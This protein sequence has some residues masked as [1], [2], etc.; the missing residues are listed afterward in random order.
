M[1]AEIVMENEIIRGPLT[2]RITFLG[3]TAVGKTSI[4]NRII[5]NN[6]TAQYDPTMKV[7]CYGLNLNIS[8][9]NVAKKTYVMTSL[10]DT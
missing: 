5:N 4:I 6:F 10:E 8:E 9:N 7:E 2:V 1:N 3:N